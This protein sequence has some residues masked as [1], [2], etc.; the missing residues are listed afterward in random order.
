MSSLSKKVKY[1]LV[2]TFEASR[3]TILDRDTYE[4]PYKCRR[5][6]PIAC[7]RGPQPDCHQPAH[8]EEP[9]AAGCGD[10]RPQVLWDS[11]RPLQAGR[12]FHIF[13]YSQELWGPIRGPMSIWESNLCNVELIT[14]G[15]YN[16]R[17][18]M[19]IY[20][21]FIFS[22]K[23]NA[24]VTLF[25]FKRVIKAFFK[26]ILRTFAMFSVSFFNTI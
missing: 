8:P 13:I 16:F 19:L 9:L 23:V 7:S 12:W 11:Q 4:D 21:A 10:T 17:C 18:F 25:Y 3:F 1:L 2:C 22:I 5:F 15:G 14:S 6:N 20:K 24:I 26:Q